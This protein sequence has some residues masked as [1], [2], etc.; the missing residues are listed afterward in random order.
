MIRVA[1]NQVRNHGWWGCVFAVLDRCKYFPAACPSVWDSLVFLVSSRCLLPH[2]F[3]LCLR[4]LLQLTH[5]NTPHQAVRGMA[6][7]ILEVSAP[8]SQRLS[9]ERDGACGCVC[10]CVCL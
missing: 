10:A 4:F 8:P 6:A 2:N 3:A 1:A 7:A 5:L 9:P